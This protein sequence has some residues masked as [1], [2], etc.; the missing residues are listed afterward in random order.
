MIHI[1]SYGEAI[2]GARVEGLYIYLHP[3]QPNHNHPLAS[4]YDSTEREAAAPTPY[5]EAKIAD[6]YEG[7]E[8]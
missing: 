4:V 5:Q 2:S 6:R 3:E 1:F 7:T 8:I